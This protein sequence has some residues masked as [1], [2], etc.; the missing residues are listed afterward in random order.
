MKTPLFDKIANH[1]SLGMTGFHTPGH[2]QGHGCSEEFNEEIREF[3]LKMDLTEL[4][5]LDN[6]KYP[7]GCIKEAQTLAARV[8]D[9][10][11]TFFLVNGSTVGLQAAI[12]AL[13]RPQGKA[14]VSR[15]ALISILNAFVL[16][17]GY[18]V[19]APVMVDYEW[20]IALGTR[21]EKLMPII[22]KN[23]DAQAVI[24][25]QPSYHGVAVDFAQM[26]RITTQ[27]GIPLI[28]DEAHGSH[29][30]FQD[31]LPI[32]AQ[33][34]KADIVVQSTH[35]T[36]G[37]LTQASMLHVNTEK[38]IK[39]VRR[40]LDILQT[41]SPS[42]LLMASLDCVQSQMHKEGNALLEKTFELA[43]KLCASIRNLSGYRIFADELDAPWYSDPTKLVISATGIGLTG[44]ELAAILRQ[45]YSIEVELSD[46]FF[47]LIV[48]TIGHSS[49]DITRLSKALEHICI[50]ERKK[51]KEAL[52]RPAS[53]YEDEVRLCLTPRQVF[54]TQSEETLLA[55]SAGRIAGEPLTVYPPGIP[56]VWPGQII[57]RQHLDYLHWAARHGFKIQGVSAGNLLT[58]LKEG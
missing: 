22:E 52:S 18:P 2:Q 27:K 23:P 7:V 32:S 20:G 48:L 47:V 4:S 53:L 37:A 38:W 43:Q 34:H 36:L 24:L 8:F 16:S 30:Y 56:L 25:T 28:A 54:E 55:E 42:Y 6:L 21:A 50:D 26:M 15:Q 39:P 46:Y 44:W 57:E 45:R 13:N 33:K 31:M 11:Q 40:A 35:K 29:L 19:I 41:T 14:I 51:A 1:I 12:L 3:L 17:G 58:V 5:G 9:A 10:R 49:E